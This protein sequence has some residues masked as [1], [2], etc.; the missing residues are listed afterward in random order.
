MRKIITCK[1]NNKFLSELV[2]QVFFHLP[3]ALITNI[4]ISLLLIIVLW[5]SVPNHILLAWISIIWLIS[6]SRF[7]L[8]YYYR[9]Y[10]VKTIAPKFWINFFTLGV[11]LSG[12][13]WG[14][15]GPLF[16]SDEFPQNNVFIAFALG[17]MIAGAAN[18][19][20]ALKNAMRLYI[21]LQLAPIIVK[22]LLFMVWIIS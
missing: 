22:C 19:M 17:G 18:S 8:L 9:R 13:A 21:V 16:F 2:E 1:N 7:T 4:L 10:A 14:V 3:A 11:I 5:Q 6:F 15:S 20:A 12:I